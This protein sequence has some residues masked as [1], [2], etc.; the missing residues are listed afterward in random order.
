MGRV[1]TP[2]WAAAATLAGVAVGLLAPGG[3]PPAPHHTLAVSIFLQ[4][5]EPYVLIPV[6]AIVA[7]VCAWRRWWD[8]LALCLLGST[9]PVALNT[10]VLK[11]LFDHR[12]KGDLAYP[13]GHTVSLVSVLA[14]LVIL[15]RRVLVAVL[16]VAVTVV[17]GIG[18]VGA[19]YHYPA[20]VAG[21]ACFAVAAVLM[22]AWAL[23]RA[24]APSAGS[25]RGG[26]SSGN[27]PAASPR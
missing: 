27:P 10:W 7:G 2:S 25:P 13:S 20:D 16:A 11:P 9:V 15:I 19:G 17:G 23:R 8:R 18:L 6:V 26:T 3:T 12:L 24:R 14:V 22:I 21:G 1:A 5:S 4:P